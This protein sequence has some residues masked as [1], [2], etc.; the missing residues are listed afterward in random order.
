[1][2]TEHFATDNSQPAQ[3]PGVPTWTTGAVVG[4]VGLGNL[5]LPV[6]RRL[7][8][9]G[10]GV[11]G[12]DISP[13]AR[14]AAR[15]LKLVASLRDLAERSDIVLVLVSDADQCAEAFSGSEGLASGANLPSA[16]VVMATL[17]PDAVVNLVA[18]LEE[19]GIMAID[20]PVSGGAQAA[21]KG[22][23]SLMVGGRPESIEACRNVLELLG[24]LHVMGKL[25]AGQSAKLAN[26]ILFF[27]TQAAMQEA[28]TLAEAD[29]IDRTALLQALSGGTAD[30]WSVRH[31]GF[32]QQT[33]WAYDA[34]GIDPSHR[35]W[36]KDLRKAAQLTAERGVEAP[37]TSLIAR[38][39]GDRVD[40]SARDEGNASRS[41]NYIEPEGAT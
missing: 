6:A 26:Q 16:I 12:F 33:A 24:T 21:L 40:R 5:G 23:L 15:G 7:D 35:P 10:V 37:V 29:G 8:A 19:L 32:L 28:I 22:E 30:C 18:P 17:G 39:F 11:I 20:V 13:V 31:P 34:A 2:T 25:G 4:V 36:H 14:E 27:G 41:I 38:I 3:M 1:M 9:A